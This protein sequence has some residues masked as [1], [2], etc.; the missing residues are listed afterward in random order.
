MAD[1][2]SGTADDKAAEVNSGG[3]AADVQ[4]GTADHKAD[5]E[6]PGGRKMAGRKKKEEKFEIEKAFARLEEI[7]SLLSREQAELAASIELYREGVMLVG[8]CREYLSGVEKELRIINDEPR[9]A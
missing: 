6:N 2:Q 4:S 7:N 1:A 8:R 5:G 3:K 9:H